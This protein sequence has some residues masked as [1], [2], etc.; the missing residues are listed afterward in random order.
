[1]TLQLAV[2][3]HPVPHLD[4]FPRRKQRLELDARAKRGN[5][6]WPRSGKTRLTQDKFITVLSNQSLVKEHLVE[7]HYGPLEGERSAP[8]AVLESV[9]MTRSS[10]RSQS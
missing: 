2:T 1:M 10:V 9:K 8:K 3:M 6:D 5:V 4:L 7:S